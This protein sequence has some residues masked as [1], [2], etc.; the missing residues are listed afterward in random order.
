MMLSPVAQ[1]NSK[2]PS[3]SIITH[4]Y[5]IDVV[6]DVSPQAHK[7]F[8]TTRAKLWVEGSTFF[9]SNLQID[10]GRGRLRHPFTL[11]KRKTGGLTDYQ[12]YS[13]RQVQEEVDM[14]TPDGL[15]Q[16]KQLQQ[17]AAA[18]GEGL[19]VVVM[20]V[21]SSGKSS[22]GRE[23]ARALGCAFFDADDFHSAH[24]KE[25]MSKGIA[26][27]DADRQPWLESLAALLARHLARHERV[28]LAC[29]ALKPAYRTVLRSAAHSHILPPSSSPSREEHPPAYSWHAPLAGSAHPDGATTGTKLEAAA[30][31]EVP[32]EPGPGPGPRLG[33]DP[34][35]GR[36]RAG[37]GVTAGAET[38]AQAPST[39]SSQTGPGPGPE[40]GP[41]SARADNGAAVGGKNG[42]VVTP[43]G[44]TEGS[45]GPGPGPGPG[46]G[47]GLGAVLQ[48]GAG[49]PGG[50]VVFVH[51]AGP[52]SLFAERIE[53]RYRQGAHYM[54]PSLL[55][56][57]IDALHVDSREGD[58]WTVDASKPIGA[59]VEEVVPGLLQL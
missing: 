51:L 59:I 23:L 15:H 4:I 21:T 37:K 7:H 6:R 2:A 39:S 11:H 44:S 31:S 16:Q 27:T 19:A 30:P 34:G 58:I 26:L 14:A 10:Q 36:A 1:L 38:G 13:E 12:I 56:S 17:T 45:T 35:L 18:G 8:T 24:S 57:Q 46:A 29:S 54:P 47:P 48:A 22:V 43:V 33:P 5:V 25:L 20:G 32:A 40:S 42:A 50:R 28:V 52:A 53:R 9:G 49:L 55:Q 41:G 3:A